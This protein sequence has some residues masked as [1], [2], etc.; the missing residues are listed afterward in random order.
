M[1]NPTPRDGRQ[2][3]R[4][5]AFKPDEGWQRSFD[6]PIELPSGRRLLTLHDAATDI[7]GLPKKESEVLE[8]RSAIYLDALFSLISNPIAKACCSV[9]I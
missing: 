4:L 9:L 8:W 2:R 5:A 3:E 6:E 7:A 1:Q